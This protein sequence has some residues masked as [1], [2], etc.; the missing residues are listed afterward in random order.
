MS[1]LS[2]VKIEDFK[3]LLQEAQKSH[4][5]KNE[6]IPELGNDLSKIESSLRTP[7]QTFS[8]TD[9]YKGFEKKAAMLF[10]LLIK[11]HPLSNGN[12]RMAC[13]TLAFF[14][15]KSWETLG[16]RSIVF[17]ISNYKFTAT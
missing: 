15:V 11:N 1:R 10:Y 12:K 3:L 9:L 8:G 5:V 13:I 2:S 16:R 6:P 17:S 4:I 7:F 14:A